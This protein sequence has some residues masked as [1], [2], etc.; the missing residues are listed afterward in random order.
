VQWK[1]E[2][3]ETECERKSSPLGFETEAHGEE[4]YPR[5]ELASLF[6][7]GFIEGELIGEQYKP[8]LD[9]FEGKCLLLIEREEKK[10]PAP[11]EAGIGF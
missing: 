4:N 6:A 7:F 3:K 8:E 1:E 9:R 11:R 5:T 2:W 10:I